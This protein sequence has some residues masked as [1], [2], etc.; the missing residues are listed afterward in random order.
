[1]VPCYISRYTTSLVFFFFSRQLT[2]YTS[3][4]LFFFVKLSVI[5]FWGNYNFETALYKIET[6]D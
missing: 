3:F 2:L 5:R 4:A 6:S 1:M